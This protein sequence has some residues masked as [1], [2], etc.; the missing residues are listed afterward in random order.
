MPNY[1]NPSESISLNLYASRIYRI[2][3]DR[4]SVCGGP[5]LSA[6]TS[7][8]T[9]QRRRPLFFGQQQCGLFWRRT[10]LSRV[11]GSDAGEAERHK[12][13]SPLHRLACRQLPGLVPITHRLCVA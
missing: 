13:Q 4:D 9:S 12:T 8:T 2:E 10:G 6:E 1:Y 3:D 7:V 5:G 11:G